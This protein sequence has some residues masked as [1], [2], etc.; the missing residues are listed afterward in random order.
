M[1]ADADRPMPASPDLDDER[2]ELLGVLCEAIERDRYFMSPRMKRLR[3]ILAKFDP[4]PPRPQPYPPPR[5]T[6]DA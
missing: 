1:P 5:R 2:A 3:A 4:P 6:G